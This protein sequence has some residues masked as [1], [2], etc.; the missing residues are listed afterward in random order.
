MPHIINQCLLC[1]SLAFKLSVPTGPEAQ[2]HRGEVRLHAE[3]PGL[4]SGE[5]RRHRPPHD[6]LRCHPL[7]PRPRGHPGH[8]IPGQRSVDKEELLSCGLSLPPTLGCFSLPT[9][10]TCTPTHSPW[11]CRGHT[12]GGHRCV[13]GNFPSADSSPQQGSCMLLMFY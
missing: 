5:D 1:L 13:V 3:D 9:K 12:L 10:H 7:L 11:C 4:W 8:G 6:T 2:Q